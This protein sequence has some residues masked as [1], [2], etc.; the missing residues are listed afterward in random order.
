MGIALGGRKP[1]VAQ[2]LLDRPQVR[3]FFQ[4][5]GSKRMTQRLWVDVGGQAMRQ[6]KLLDDAAYATGRQPAIAAQPHI[7]QQR[8]ARDGSPPP[9]SAPVG[10]DT[11]E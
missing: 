11:R 9:V 1:G 8:F 3:A 5:V 7:Q 10:E 4:H 6:G 2:N